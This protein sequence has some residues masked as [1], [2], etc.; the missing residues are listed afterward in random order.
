MD[1]SLPRYTHVLKYPIKVVE[2]R[3]I[4]AL[5]RL[6]SVIVGTGHSVKGASDGNDNVILFPDLSPQAYFESDPDDIARLA[7]VM[8]TRTRKGLYLASTPRTSRR[9]MALEWLEL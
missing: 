5:Q 7:Y 3:G 4:A 8:M 6:P 2:K 9:P 1:H